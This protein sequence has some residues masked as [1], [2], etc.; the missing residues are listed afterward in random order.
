MFTKIRL[1]R[2]NCAVKNSSNNNKQGCVVLKLH[3]WSVLLQQIRKYLAVRKTQPITIGQHFFSNPCPIAIFYLMP[4]LQ[5]LGQVAHGVKLLQRVSL[6]PTLM[7]QQKDFLK[8]CP[9]IYRSYSVMQ[10]N[11]DLY[12]DN[13]LNVTPSISIMEHQ[14]IKFQLICYR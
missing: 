12:V 4:C 6:D 13:Y 3:K 5:Q 1:L 10:W 2:K 8:Q 14:I 9:G 11:S 7:F